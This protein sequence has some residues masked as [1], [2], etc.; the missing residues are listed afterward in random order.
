MKIE[1]SCPELMPIPNL[2]GRPPKAQLLVLLI[3]YIG[4]FYETRRL[5]DNRN[6]PINSPKST[7]GH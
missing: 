7:F 4:Y 6:D 1:N 3:A 5:R 2:S